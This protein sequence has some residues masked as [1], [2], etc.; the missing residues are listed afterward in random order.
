MKYLATV[1]KEYD[2]SSMMFSSMSAAER[3][4]DENN[5]NMEH[6][7]FIEEYDDNW[8]KVSSFVYTESKR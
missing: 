2:S 8:N 3:W 4:L 1:K 5:N 6:L 7:T